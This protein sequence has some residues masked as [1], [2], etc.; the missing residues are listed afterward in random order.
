MGSLA[1]VLFFGN[2]LWDCLGKVGDDFLQKYEL[3]KN[4]AV[5][6]DNIAIIED[7]KTVD[8]DISYLAGGSDPLEKYAEGRIS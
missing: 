7:M 2:P 8:S 5:L 1:K 3:E 4:N 6:R